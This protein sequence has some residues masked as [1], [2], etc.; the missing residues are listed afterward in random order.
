M[1]RKFMKKRKDTVLS[2]K[3]LIEENHKLLTSLGVFI[4][5]TMFTSNLALKPLGTYLSS[6]FLGLSI[7][8]WIEVVKAMSIDL[9]KPKDLTLVLAQLLVMPSVP[10]FVIY[11]LTISYDIWPNSLEYVL[12]L[13]IFL[14]FLKFFSKVPNKLFSKTQLICAKSKAVRKIVATLFYF[15]VTG[16]MILIASLFAFL[17][18]RLIRAWLTLWT[19]R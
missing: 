6:I 9:E 5:L 18:G 4:A 19:S 8:I 3:Q 7:I 15:A 11:W 16:C 17:L 12:T 1:V 2:L 10:L 14:L 13:F